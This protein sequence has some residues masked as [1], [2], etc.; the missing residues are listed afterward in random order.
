LLPAAAVLTL[1]SREVVWAW[2]GDLA[3]VAAIRY[4]LIAVAIGSA[5][6]GLMNIPYAL[7][8]A[9]GWTRLAAWGNAIAVVV[10][11][12]LTY[13]LAKA[14]GT[15]GA[16]SGWAVLNAGY[17]IFMVHIM[18]L[19][20]LRSEQRRW[21]ATDVGVPLIGT[22]IAIIPI[23]LLVVSPV[24]RVSSLVIVL[25]SGTAAMMGAVLASPAV[26]RRRFAGAPERLRPP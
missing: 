12:P 2:T 10:I 5:L 21:Y 1:F 26:R 25:V 19:K 20:L 9:Y 24:G 22:L 18:H 6:N 4:V 13:F 11:V 23:R 8:L 3:T 17:V 15:V 7:Q 16:A 14:F